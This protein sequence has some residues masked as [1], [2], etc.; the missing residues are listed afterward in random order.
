[1]IVN[2]S[3]DTWPQVK[4]APTDPSPPTHGLNQRVADDA[5]LSI[6]K[7]SE[8]PP[9]QSILEDHRA[10][11]NSEDALATENEL[12]KFSAVR[13]PGES[14]FETRDN[15][16][17]FP[18][19]AGFRCAS[20]RRA[21]TPSGISET[22]PSLSFQKPY[23]EL[24]AKISEH[25]IRFAERPFADVLASL[26]SDF[27]SIIKDE[28][29][30]YMPDE[31]EK[32]PSEP[33]LPETNNRPG[34]RRYDEDDGT[35][36]ETALGSFFADDEATD[37]EPD[38]AT[39][40]AVETCTSAESAKVQS[41][42]YPASSADAAMKRTLST[43]MTLESKESSKP[44]VLPAN[45]ASTTDLP[46]TADVQKVV[47]L[48]NEHYVRQHGAPQ[49]EAKTATWLDETQC[50]QFHIEDPGQ[51]GI[52]AEP[53]QLTPGSLNQLDGE[54]T[55]GSHEF[56]QGALKER[57][58]ASSSIDIESH[59]SR[60][61]SFEP[62]KLK[63]LTARQVPGVDKRVVTLRLS[64]TC[65]VPPLRTLCS[66]V[67]PPAETVEEKHTATAKSVVKTPSCSSCARL[68]TSGTASASPNETPSKKRSPRA[69]LSLDALAETTATGAGHQEGALSE[70]KLRRRGRKHRRS[71]RF[72]RCY[73][74]SG[75]LQAG[76][77]LGSGQRH[78]SASRQPGVRARGQESA[79][80]AGGC[81]RIPELRVHI[82][83]HPSSGPPPPAE[84]ALEEPGDV[85]SRPARRASSASRTV[86]FDN[87]PT[88]VPLEPPPEPFAV[89]DLSQVD[90]E[91][92]ATPPQFHR[93]RRRSSLCC[94]SSGSLLQEVTDTAD[95][96]AILDARRASLQLASLHLEQG[97]TPDDAA[98]AA[99]TAADPDTTRSVASAAP[100]ATPLTS[101]FYSFEDTVSELSSRP[102]TANLNS[103]G[104]L[105]A[106]QRSEGAGARD[107]HRGSP[108]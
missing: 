16:P 8:K 78:I 105:P 39:D 99:K 20:R 42:H 73:P 29:K 106:S 21:S 81:T 33:Q 90:A 27:A 52:T 17:S 65:N 83:R 66:Q 40:E 100:T 45:S 82:Q 7:T 49:R 102:D 101:S 34:F 60:D 94:S 79:P 91:Q 30:V 44:K 53:Q 11:V 54:L 59:E 55:Q 108:A 95:L 98:Y 37:F 88:V 48:G 18:E 31:K 80:S 63:D 84:T 43:A 3:V 1:M 50:V 77:R 64:K 47:T 9:Q 62:L 19:A 57:P 22:A 72:L 24:M 14:I 87:S 23:Q 69:R 97:T 68:G 25:Q 6:G 92:A 36:G 107:R 41:R 51:L 58:A 71:A 61:A 86:S 10:S 75:T 46:L 28:Q 35:L 76:Q 96:I 2:A 56:I 70:T 13:E 74:P 104:S 85:P 26:E 67:L 15:S 4:F 89:R 5:N 38:A 32:T 93:Q 12:M 103:S